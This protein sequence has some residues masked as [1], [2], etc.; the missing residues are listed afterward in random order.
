MIDED[1]VWAHLMPWPG[2]PPKGCRLVAPD[3]HRAVVV[4]GRYLALIAQDNCVVAV[5]VD[6]RTCSRRIAGH[7][8]ELTL[9]SMDVHA[10][11]GDD[12]FIIVG[13]RSRV[14]RRAQHVPLP[15]HV[16]PSA[17]ARRGQRCVCIWEGPGVLGTGCRQ[18]Y[19]LAALLGVMARLGVSRWG[20]ALWC[21]L[22]AHCRPGATLTC[23]RRCR[24]S[25]PSLL[26]H[27]FLERMRA[28]GV[29]PECGVPLELV[30]H[31]A[32]LHHQALHIVSQGARLL[33]ALV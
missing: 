29:P 32:P 3:A 18:R 1:L 31:V 20:A 7:A 26:Y 22:K 14:G 11:A 5:V 8:R 28:E 17:Q 30:V 19:V 23:S 27:Y 33:R 4:G 25:P 13:R 12:A 9:S 10:A 2:S 6:G 24:P 15:P 21:P 16:L